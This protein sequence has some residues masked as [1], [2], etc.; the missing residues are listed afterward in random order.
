MLYPYQGVAEM[1][2]AGVVSVNEL[3]DVVWSS[4]TDYNAF[5]VLIK[6]RNNYIKRAFYPGCDRGGALAE[7]LEHYLNNVCLNLTPTQIWEAVASAIQKCGNTRRAEEIREKLSRGEKII[8]ELPQEYAGEE[9]HGYYSSR[10]AQQKVNAAA[11]YNS[12]STEWL[13]NS[14]TLHYNEASRKIRELYIDAKEALNNEEREASEILL[15]YK[16]NGD[17][18][19]SECE[20]SLNELAERSSCL[21]ELLKNVMTKLDSGNCTAFPVMKKVN[22]EYAEV[23]KLLPKAAREVEKY[24]ELVSNE[25]GDS[26]AE[27]EDVVQSLKA[28]MK[29][30][31]V[32]TEVNTTK[33]ADEMPVDE[34]EYQVA[35]DW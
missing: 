29:V 4:I 33:K 15:E 31:T 34:D 1:A 3:F 9:Y 35:Q 6:V 8:F 20:I 2:E 11:D 14:T 25:T 10:Q 16:T 12:E 30:T 32:S 24:R 23:K 27:T 7:C 5:L 28:I 22:D 13:K 21:E 17:K 26:V 19:G 18:Q